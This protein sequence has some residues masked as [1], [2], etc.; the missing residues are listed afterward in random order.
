MRPEG[1]RPL[2]N[3]R[4]IW[5]DNI[6]LDLQE[7]EWGFMGQVDL[8]QDRNSRRALVNAVVKLLVP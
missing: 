4:S 8:G 7:V 2:G 6:K 5:Q 3:S 1:E